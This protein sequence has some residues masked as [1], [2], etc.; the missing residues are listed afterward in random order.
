ME[1]LKELLLNFLKETYPNGYKATSTAYSLYVWFSKENKMFYSANL[2]SGTQNMYE[3]NHCFKE[4]NYVTSED[5]FNEAQ[6]NF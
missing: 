2:T 4:W 3:H 6:N 5:M 1:N